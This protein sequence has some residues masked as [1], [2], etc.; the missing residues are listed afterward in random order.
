MKRT[1]IN[2]DLARYGFIFD[3]DGT[4]VD[5]MRY[6]MRAWT[7]M[8]AENGIEN[9]G[10]DFLVN[11]AGKTNREIIPAFFGDTSEEELIRYG[12]R[13]EELY[14]KFFR[15]ELKPVE[16]APDFLEKADRLGIKM[17]LATSAPVENMEFILD[18]LD[19]RRFFRAVTTAA[20]VSKGKP[21]PEAFLL[22]AEKLD[23]RPENCIVFED[24][25]LGFEAARRAGMRSV[26]ITTVNPAE[27]ILQIPSAVEAREN[28]IGLE[29]EG[30][31]EKYL[32]H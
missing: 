1:P 13:K 26:G 29:P 9:N 16:G 24:A 31:I 23:V 21:H 17:A 4:L 12:N 15:P 27:E 6:H 28:F 3:M 19:L 22:S 14:R 7:E 10:H 11:T 25:L 5:N 32:T 30:L 2:A 18:G 20:D 8:L